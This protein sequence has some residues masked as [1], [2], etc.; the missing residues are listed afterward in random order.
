MSDTLG[1]LQ[2]S[3]HFPP[4][5][6]LDE[7]CP[8]M[9]CCYPPD[10]IANLACS[11]PAQYH[12]RGKPVYTRHIELY[13]YPS[14]TAS[15]AAGSSAHI[16]GV[17]YS[18]TE[19]VVPVWIATHRGELVLIM[20]DLGG[21]GRGRVGRPAQWQASQSGMGPPPPPIQA[22]AAH[23]AT[24]RPGRGQPLPQVSLPL[25]AKPS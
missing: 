3:A 19:G 15:C 17:E 20:Q 1:P 21:R 8:H 4:W 24:L 22:L 5:Q 7:R 9:R 23:Q 2:S 16:R 13:K 11:L 25:A 10:V 14:L 18:F 12:M 6:A